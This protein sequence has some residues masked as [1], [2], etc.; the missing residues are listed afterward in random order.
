MDKFRA[1]GTFVQ[2]ADA[3]SLT[4]AAWAMGA[5]LPSV[6]RSLAAYEAAL[7]VRL[8]NRTTRRIALT[9]EGRRHL[10]SC[11][12]LLAAVEDAEA[13][14]KDDDTEPTGKLTITAPVLFGQM[15]VAPIVTRFVE[16]HA[17][18]R[19]RV[20]L[21]DRVVNLLEEGIDLG[22]RIGALEDSNLIALRLGDIRRVV[23]A[24]PAFLRAQG[25]PE[26]PND[27][28]RVNCVRVVDHTPSW[29]LFRDGGKTFK[30]NVKGNL[31]FNHIAPAVQACAAGAGFGQ[32]FSY[33]VAP[34][35][36]MGQLQT[37]LENFEDAPWPIHVVYPHARLLPAR[38]RAFIDFLRQ[39]IRGFESGASASETPLSPPVKS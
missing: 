28:M 36:Q 24:S 11:R 5:S 38:T 22:I 4:A 14:L 8:F 16:R 12:Q 39:E 33:Q 7:G 9:D 34:F 21:L 35:L 15:H 29:G 6:V 19:C 17:Q 10:E 30:L 1:M 18:M 32:F 27:L 2:I 31:E 13:A 25:R 3:G 20:M 37:V 26:H 23:V